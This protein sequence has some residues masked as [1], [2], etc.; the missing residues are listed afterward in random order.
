MRRGRIIAFFAML[1]TTLGVGFG[2]TPGVAS[3]ASPMDIC[4]D[5]SAH[6]GQLSGHYS[7]TELSAFLTALG[8]DPVLQGYC[9]PLATLPQCS[10]VSPGTPGS[11]VAPNGKSYVNAP[12]NKAEVCGPATQVC[13]EAAPHATGAVQAS[14]GT[15]YTNLPPAGVEACGHAAPNATI[16]VPVSTPSS[17]VKGATKVKATKKAPTTPRSTGVSPAQHTRSAAPL[18]T[19]KSSGALPFTGA[20]LGIFAVVGIALLTGGLL[21][22]LTARQKRTSA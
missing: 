19:T 2:V 20:E 15:W 5:L 3:A 14:N 10:E 12:D 6:G 4:N 17:G 13:I 1:L 18:A 16:V 8:S 21:L 22:R 7:A 11:L 9:S